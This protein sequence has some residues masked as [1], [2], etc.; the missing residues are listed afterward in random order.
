MVDSKYSYMDSRIGSAMISSLVESAFQTGCLS[1]ES[2]AL[3]RQVLTARI[4]K[5]SDVEALRQLYDAVE[6]G[7]IRREGNTKVQMPLPS[8]RRD[9]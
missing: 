6:T 7:H 8:C 5:P 3:M 1:V 9:W 2:E 4:Y